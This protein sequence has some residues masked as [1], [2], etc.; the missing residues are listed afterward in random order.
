MGSKTPTFS[1]LAKA[2]LHQTLFYFT[3]LFFN[4]YIYI[5][6]FFFHNSQNTSLCSDVIFF[7]PAPFPSPFVPDFIFPRPPFFCS[8]YPF[9]FCFPIGNLPFPAAPFLLFPVPILFLFPHRQP[10]ISGVRRSIFRGENTTHTNRRPT[11]S[12]IGPSVKKRPQPPK[13]VFAIDPSVKKP[14]TPV[15]WLPS[16]VSFLLLLTHP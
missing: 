12:T 7:P 3:I 8:P 15:I 10:P 1:S 4:I 9:F 11:T 5:Y 14:P 2:Q 16:S 13:S 6:F